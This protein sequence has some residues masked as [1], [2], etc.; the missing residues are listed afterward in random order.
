[1]MGFLYRAVFRS[2]RNVLRGRAT[3]RQMLASWLAALKLPFVY[4]GLAKDFW[5]K[6]DNYPM[7]EGGGRSSF[8]VIPFE[9]DP[10]TGADGPAP[11]RR[12]TR[13]RASDISD[14]IRNLKLRGCEIGLHG[15][16]AWLDA[17]KAREEAE[18]IRRVSGADPVGVRMHWLY[19]N[20]QSP[21]ILEQAGMD[22][23]STV[24]YNET[25][26]FRAGT[27]QVYKPLGVDRLLELPL[28]VMDTALFYPSHMDLP[29]KEA[30]RRVGRIIDCADRFGGTITVNWH[31]RSIAAERCWDDFYGD[32][33]RELQSRGA[34]LA[35][36]AEVVS[37]FRK[38]RAAT[39][40][41]EAGSP[42]RY[43]VAS[44]VERHDALP[45]LRL[46]INNVEE[47]RS[48]VEAIDVASRA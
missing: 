2:V 42:G 24:G 46:R 38:R 44:T 28:H 39:F 26:G 41:V 48:P 33:V 23:D 5:L 15:I 34:W 17:A 22:Y 20:E 9:N 30:W 10:G 16:N 12:A 25:V 3:L 27:T 18:E 7:L 32:L 29:P 40:E 4:L 11:G 35:P 8:F 6:F 45:K 47:R 36:A 19:F 13:Y 31:D 1:M 14:Q 21:I 43:S 37:W